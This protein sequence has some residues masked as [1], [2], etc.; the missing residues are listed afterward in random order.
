MYECT[1]GKPVLTQDYSPYASYIC[2]C[3]QGLCFVINEAYVY[4]NELSAVPLFKQDYLLTF[5]P[6][7]PD[8]CPEKASDIS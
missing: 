5:W 6:M 3:Y 8:D 1:Y 2:K 7:I 4:D